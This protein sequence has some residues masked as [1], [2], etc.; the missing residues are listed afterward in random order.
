MDDEEKEI[1]L[2]DKAK[3][4][5]TKAYEVA[6]FLNNRKAWQAMQVIPELKEIFHRCGETWDEGVL[7]LRE[8]LIEISLNQGDLGLPSGS[9]LPLYFTDE[10][11][12]WHK[13]QFTIY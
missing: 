6:S 4:T 13:H 11:I 12:A 1:A 2:Y 10:Q 3:A 8:I 5:W 7:P 9:R